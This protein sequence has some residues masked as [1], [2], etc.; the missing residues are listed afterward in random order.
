MVVVQVSIRSHFGVSFSVVWS[1]SLAVHR[2]AIMDVQEAPVVDAPV[3]QNLEQG[4]SPRKRIHSKQPDPMLPM[5]RRQRM[6]FKQPAQ[7]EPIAQP[8]PGEVQSYMEVPEA[9]TEVKRHVK[10]LYYRLDRF[11]ARDLGKLQNVAKHP[12]LASLYTRSLKALTRRDKV[13]LVEAWL[14]EGSTTAEYMRKF[15]EAWATGDLLGKVEA[16]M[17][18]GQQGLFTWNGDWG[19]L[20][21]D[22]ILGDEWP[23]V[24]EV[25]AILKMG[26]YLQELIESM[27]TLVESLKKNITCTSSV[28]PSSCLRK[29]TRW[30]GL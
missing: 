8:A 25:V 18:T 3:A 12:R 16:K 23:P 19:V 5:P 2:R 29:G 21:K 1:H 7:M 26:N 14:L 30:L 20:N 28:G 9:P 24:E 6:L 27:D 17:W 13:K 11:R 22:C 15:A 10:A 4:G